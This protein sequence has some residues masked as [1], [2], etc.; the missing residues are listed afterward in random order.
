MLSL[1]EGKKL[2]A[3]VFA[4][5]MTASVFG[6]QKNY[7]EF[8]IDINNGSVPAGLK[9]GDRAPDFI[10]YDQKGKK[11]ESPKLLEKGPLVIF[12]YRGKWS[13]VCNEYLGNYQDSLN[14][15]TDQGVTLVGITPESIENVEQTVNNNKITY[16]VLYDCEEKIMIDYD[17]LFNVTREY[18]LKISDET[19]VDIAINNG[20]DAARLPVTATYIINRAG[21]IVAVHFNPDYNNRASVKWVLYNLGKAFL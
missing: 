12:F 16:T 15:I 5:L 9:V 20:R 10:A 8:G 2:S 6:Q 3:I 19:S 4:L 14:F 1:I 21:N 11:I 13:S 18:Q 17:V 7:S